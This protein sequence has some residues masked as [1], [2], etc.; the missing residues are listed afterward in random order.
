[1]IDGKWGLDAFLRI[2]LT[3]GFL[4]SHKAQ[5][6]IKCEKGIKMGWMRSFD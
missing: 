2:D 4:V 3:P 5:R 6:A 1:L